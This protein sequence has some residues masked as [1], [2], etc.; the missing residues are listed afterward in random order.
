MDLHKFILNKRT[1]HLFLSMNSNQSRN[2][3]MNNL[4]LFTRNRRSLQKDNLLLPQ[5]A[6]EKIVFRK[7]KSLQ[8][9]NL[10][11]PLE[12]EEKVVFPKNK[13]F[14][15]KINKIKSL[16]CNKGNLNYIMKFIFLNS[17]KKK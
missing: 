15:K 1:N 5:K 12:V 10:L 8:K 14:L 4:I 2:K 16:F 3:S 6:E 7:K 17:T 11:Q 13:I 9:D